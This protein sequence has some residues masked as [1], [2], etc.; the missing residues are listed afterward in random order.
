MQ[1]KIYTFILFVLLVISPPIS[2]QFTE[3]SIES[4][5]LFQH[6]SALMIGGG[7]VF[8]DYNN[9]GWEDIYLAGGG[10]SDALYH[11]NGDGTFSNISETAG[12]KNLP[13][14]QT[15]GAISADI[16][17]DGFRDVFV[18]TWDT[19]PNM[20]LHNNGDGTFTEIGQQ[21]GVADVSFSM[22]A[23]FGDYNVDGYLDLYVGNYLEENGG[24]DAENGFGHEGYRNFFYINQGD[25]TFEEVGQ[26]Y[27]LDDAGCALAVA[28]TDY[29]NDSDVDIYV[30]N[31]F[32]EWVLP[33][34]I[35]ANSYPTDFFSNFNT[36]TGLDIKI[37]AMGIAI[38][39]YNED[40]YFDYYV[41]NLGRNRLLQNQGLNQRF[42]DLAIQAGVD[43]TYSGID[44][45]T[46][47][48]LL[49]TSWGTAF[50]DYDND[51]Y[52]DL[53]VSNGHIPAVNDLKN[54]E[55]DPNKLY[56]NNQANGTFTDVSDDMGVANTDVC[57]GMAVADYDNDGDMDILV[58][59]IY[60]AGRE[61]TSENHVLL[62]RND[63]PPA[64]WL[65]VE[66]KGVTN[67]K[68]G[69]GSHVEVKVDGRTFMREIDG[70]SSHAS[71]NS[72]IA[73][74]GLGN[75]EMIDELKVRW[76]GGAEQV[77]TNIAANQTVIIREG[78]MTAIEEHT[79]S[80]LQLTSQPNPFKESTLISYSLPK[81]SKVSLAIYDVTGRLIHQIAENE[82][83]VGKQMFDWQPSAKLAAGI[84]FCQL[85]TDFGMASHRLIVE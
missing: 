12:L 15:T 83:A 65:K 74:F 5:I 16:D 46:G 39:D 52:I 76:L 36:I 64:N 61:F 10:G 57:R 41:S 69:I 31:D 13:N 3:V 50:F 35:F 21:I 70:G 11:N 67:N 73:H 1:S 45:S 19:Q 81:S 68:Q 53:F 25:G 9:D 34:S 26:F 62:Y 72:T 43:N 79:S 78:E 84:Y 40:G 32:G 82:Q 29:D 55:V 51:T 56:R 4:G 30:A 38:G 49:A 2:A 27:G 77:F 28:F 37:Y 7:G 48:V 42:L 44:S 63:S 80:L 54:S 17:N 58:V 66:L 33:N 60:D 59:G 75:Y 6:T 18:M 47:D 14:Y 8:F 85:I 23:S 22:A 24:Y 71:Q 20:M